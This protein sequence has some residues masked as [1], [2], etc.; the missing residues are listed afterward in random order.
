MVFC[1]SN[2]IGQVNGFDVSLTIFFGGGRFKLLGCHIGWDNSVDVLW[3]L[4]SLNNVPLN[5]Y[6]SVIFTELFYM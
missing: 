4:F 1:I 6:S 3:N 2:F 5:I